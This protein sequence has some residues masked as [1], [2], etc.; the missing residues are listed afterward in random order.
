MSEDIHMISGELKKRL[1]DISSERSSYNHEEDESS[2]QNIEDFVPVSPRE[3]LSTNVLILRSLKHSSREDPEIEMEM[4]KKQL[5]IFGTVCLVQFIRQWN[6]FDVYVVYSC[7]E[8]AEIAKRELE[9]VHQDIYFAK[10]D[11]RR[12]SKK[13]ILDLP[14]NDKTFVTSPPPSPPEG[15]EPHGE[16][17]N[18]QTTVDLGD[19]EQ[20][21]DELI[22]LP[23]LNGLPK[24]IISNPE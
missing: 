1:I 10:P 15:W 22:L 17:I 23:S 13:H 16:D 7:T 21:G 18:R 12:F 2:Q 24:I 6:S 8:E 4:L 19:P 9:T 11:V 14:L 5:E 3:E 20:I